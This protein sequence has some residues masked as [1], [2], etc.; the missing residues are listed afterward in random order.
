[1]TTGSKRAHSF[2]NARVWILLGIV[3][4]ISPALGASSA[5]DDNPVVTDRPAH[6]DFR[7]IVQEAKQ[8][9]FPA[10][11][12]I[13]CLRDAH[14]SGERVSM[15]VSGSG[16]LIS[17]DGEV[18]TNWH[19]V[20]KAT[21]VRCLLYDGRHYTAEVLGTD[22]DVDLALIKLNLSEDDSHLPFAELADSNRVVE[23][24]FVMAMG[25]PLGMNRS[26]SLGIISAVRRYLPDNSEYSLWFQTDAAIS[27]GNSGGPLVNTYGEVVGINTR[28]VMYGGDIGFSVPSN[29]VTRLL[30]HLREFGQVQWSWTGIQVQPLRDFNRDIY[31]EGEHGVIVSGT[32]P[33]SPARTAGLLARDR[34]LKINDEDITAGTEED[35]PAV[36]RMLGLLPLNETSTLYIER[37]GE[38]REIS[39]TPREKG[40]VEG[41]EY[42]CPR[43]D[44]TVKAINQFDNP[45]LYFHREEGVFIL[46]TRYPGNAVQSGLSEQDILL[47]INGQSVVTIE[48]VRAIHEASLEQLPG[49]RR[50]TFTVMR[51]GQIRRHI[52]DISRDFERR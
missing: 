13:R 10:V 49:K 4:A 46:G 40:S 18:L 38:Q 51:N 23:G 1:M 43:W 41:E 7:Q 45:N 25:A 19:V 22:K 50:L 20:D 27:P 34:I 28:G 30:P 6:L 12:F 15:E 37:D 14:E 52:L 9:V 29:T 21:R 2:R 36:R 44:L 24:D 8:K 32:D 17:A 5:P 42:D 3:L 33:N 47:E 39:L 48:D 16:V 11:V 31:F 26:V 35:L